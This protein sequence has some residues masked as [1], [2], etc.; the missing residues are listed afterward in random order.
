[1][2]VDVIILPKDGSKQELQLE[3]K[4]TIKNVFKKLYL[5]VQDEDFQF[6]LEGEI[7]EIKYQLSSKNANMVFVKFECEYTPA[8]SAKVLDY[9]GRTQK[10][11]E[12]C[13]YI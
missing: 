12:Y 8:K 2:E 11:L 9:T 4:Q 5:D 10:R 1:M 3:M 7:V 6:D 13:N